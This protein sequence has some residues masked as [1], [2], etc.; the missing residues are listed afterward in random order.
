MRAKRRAERQVHD[1]RPFGA[2]GLGLAKCHDGCLI[3]VEPRIPR[4]RPG[5]DQ[6]ER[7]RGAVDGRPAELRDARH[8]VLFAVI[9]IAGIGEIERDL[10]LIVGVLTRRRGSPLF[11]S[12]QFH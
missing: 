3:R 9:C 5:K 1:R 12:P 7:V 11:P 10:E 8:C 2:L 6:I 4:T